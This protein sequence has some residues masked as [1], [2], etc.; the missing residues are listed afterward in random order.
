L[1]DSSKRRQA[2]VYPDNMLGALTE[3][4]TRLRRMPLGIDYPVRREQ[5]LIIELPTDDWALPAETLEVRHDSFRFRFQ[6]VPARQRVRLL[7][8]CETLTDEVPAHDVG[9]YLAR[10]QEMDE[11]LGDVFYRPSDSRVGQLADLNWLMIALAAGNAGLVT[12][13]SVWFLKATGSSP[14]AALPVGTEPRL[15]GLGGWLIL[16]GAVLV[17]AAIKRIV[18]IATTWDGFFSIHTWQEVAMP[19]G[20]QYHP[21]FGPL[22][23]FEVSANVWLLGLNALA[24]WLFFGKHRH[25]PV[26][27]L[28]LI[29]SNAVVFLVDKV[30]GGAIPSLA[31][32]S[33]QQPL[34][35]VPRVFFFAIIWSIYILKSRRVKATFVR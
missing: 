2:T 11:L 12:I 3:P 34:A 28:V 8:E 14:R 30:W 19:Q 32:E 24:L 35:A 9:T 21:L 10:V 33:G 20:D 16:L 7:Y 4:T 13:G 29:A 23:M 1:D 15:Q 5:E 26:L 18:L 31:D 22:L 17:F 6:S 27:F 25:F